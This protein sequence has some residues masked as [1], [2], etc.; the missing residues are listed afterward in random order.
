M[1]TYK[2]YQHCTT[3]IADKIK[4][5]I[6]YMYL[7]S[8]LLR[9]FHSSWVKTEKSHNQYLNIFHLRAGVLITPNI[10]KLKIHYLLISE[11]VSTWFLK[12]I[13]CNYSVA[14][15]MFY[16]SYK[17]LKWIVHKWNILSMK[18]NVSPIFISYAKWSMIGSNDKMDRF[19]NL[20]VSFTFGYPDWPNVTQQKKPIIA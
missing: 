3:I 15:A 1:Q 5:F 12:F 20:M 11:S 2:N 13:F 17:L 6:S 8:Y 9:S 16:S 14:S 19:P 18:L 10:S 4:I 7:F